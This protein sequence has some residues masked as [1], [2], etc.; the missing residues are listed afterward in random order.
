MLPLEKYPRTHHIEGSG[1]QAG[2]ETLPVASFFSLSGSY[3]VV[4]EKMDGAN[5][6]ISFDRRER[7]MLQ[8]RGHYLTGGPREVHFHLFKAWAVRFQTQL[9]DVLGDRFVMFGEWMYAKHTV[10]YTGLP[11][12]FMEFDIYDRE[13]QCFL[14]TARRRA[15][16]ANA[17]FI[18]PVA[19]LYTGIAPS[20][21]ALIAMVGHSLFIGPDHM[22]MLRAECDKLGIDGERALRET[23]PSMLMEG[24]YIKIEDA[25][26]VVD[27]YKYVRRTF[28]QSVVDSDSHWLDRPIILNRLRDDIDLFA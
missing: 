7:L 6:A 18:A 25:D 14:S 9:W 24:L 20:Y 21:D 27:R 22:A 12:Y 10:F 5:C 13:A 16:L 19:V 26:T 28:L 4:E 3:L 17:P 15:M 8:S 23:D 1:I 11:H 2:D